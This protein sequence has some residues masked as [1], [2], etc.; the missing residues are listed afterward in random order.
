[1]KILRYFLIPLVFSISLLSQNQIQYKPSDK[2]TFEHINEDD[3]LSNNYVTCILQDSKGYMWFGT[4]DGLNKYDGYNFTIYKHD[5]RDPFSLRQNRIT[6]LYEDK[7][8]TLWVGTGALLQNTKLRGSLNK[9]NREKEQF[10]HYTNITT[11][12]LSL[13]NSMI[14]SICENNFGDLWIGTRGGINKFDINKEQFTFLGPDVNDREEISN[15]INVLFRPNDSTQNDIWIGT[16]N[17]TFKTDNKMEKF[18]SYKPNRKNS[19]SLSGR[20]ILSIC[21]DNFGNLWLGTEG[22]GLNKFNVRIKQFVHYKHDPKNLNTLSHNQVESIYFDNYGIF[23]IGTNNGLNKFDIKKEQ[24]VRY[25]YDPR[26]PYSLSNNKVLSIFEDNSGAIWIG[27]AGGINKI[28][29]QKDQF[30]YYKHDPLN[31]NS[32]SYDLVQSVYQDKQGLLWIGTQKGLNKFDPEN[33]LFV[34]YFRDSN[35]PNSLSSNR[36]WAI[37]EDKSNNIWFGTWGGGLNKFNR[38][39][40]IFIRYKYNSKDPYSLSDNSVRIIYLDNK[41]VL[42]IGTQKGL[43]KYDD[44]KDRFI[45]YKFDFDI[46][47]NKRYNKITSLFESTIEG[48]EEFWIGTQG[49][50]LIKFDREKEKFKQY[51]N[52]PSDSNSLSNDNIWLIYQDNAGELWCSTLGG[53]N[54]LNKEKNNFTRYQFD[55]NNIANDVCKVIHEDKYGTLW[56]GSNTG[57]YKYDREKQVFIDK[58]KKEDFPKGRIDAI[59]ED[60]NGYLWISSEKYLIKFNLI[61]ETSNIYKLQNDLKNHL[62]IKN[63]YL[64][65]KDGRFIISGQKGFILFDPNKIK[66]NFTI[67]S[68]AITDFQIFN[69]TVEIKKD[70]IPENEN[71]YLLEKHISETE[72]IKIPYDKNVFSMEFAAMDFRDPAKNK[73]AY[74]LEGIDPDWV[75]TDASRRFAT[76]NQLNPGEY[77][78]YVKGSNNDGIW[79]EKGTSLKLIITPLWWQTIW[80]RI[81]VVFVIIGSVVWIFFNRINALK[82]K[83]QIQEEFSRQLIDS[84]E[85]ERKRIASALHDSHGQNLLVISNE[86]QHFV[87]DHQ[88]YKDDLKPVTEIVQESIDEI[89]NISYDLHPHQLDKLG[90]VKTIKSMVKKISGS[91]NIKFDLKIDNINDLIEKKTEI[92]IYRI[93]QEATN[94]IIKHSQATEAKIVIRK[95]SKSVTIIISDNGYGFNKKEKLKESTGLGLS[96]MLERA[97]LIKGKFNFDTQEGKGVRITFSIPVKQKE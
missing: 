78:F 69:K 50:G 37:Y 19:F 82:K 7:S 89:R 23:W 6:T 68:I 40:E 4:Q 24:F 65:C 86:V 60:D 16:D 83:Q 20:K 47:Q 75:Y 63:S 11:D 36:I 1:M 31:S 94:N 32:L 3:G 92:N 5:P 49:G 12:S 28:I 17:G 81:F 79:N 61:T 96:G 44:K 70:G 53:L 43:N 39:N 71:I 90:L 64:K 77:T 42:W 21:E 52:F 54:R 84:Q 45:Q 38:K 14:T 10:K 22:G 91:T 33:D 2:I 8:G 97:K 18:V 85:S 29:K 62:K 93:I 80:F 27:T 51:K 87:L 48:K 15:R 72:I 13:N 57:L 41:D 95:E 66:D 59:L 25:N 76:Y 9:F 30:T 88:E 67:P 58:N 34:R 46:P 55:K 26:N 35:N 73:Y 56:V 74:K